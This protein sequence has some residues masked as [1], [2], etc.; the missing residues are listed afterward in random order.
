[1]SIHAGS[2]G[3]SFMTIE[4]GA[5]DEAL[6]IGTRFEQITGKGEQWQELL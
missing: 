2:A 3:A 4:M 1:M 5:G 6:R